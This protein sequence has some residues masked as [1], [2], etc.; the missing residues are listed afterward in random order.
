MSAVEINRV[1]PASTV[2]QQLI[3]ELDV[4]LSEHYPGEPVNGIDAAEFEDIGGVFFVAR[5]NGEPAG[6][7]AAYPIDSDVAE[8]KRMFVRRE[9]RGTGV[10]AQMLKVL[11]AWAGEHG[12]RQVILETGDRLTAALRFYERSGYRRIAN[13]EPFV[14]STRS[15]CFG[16]DLA[17][18]KDES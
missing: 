8:L 16:K 6:C 12:M 7:G 10:A 2:A 9:H 3:A 4:E 1:S 17:P 18:E 13:F 5:I 11:E 15:R 14:G